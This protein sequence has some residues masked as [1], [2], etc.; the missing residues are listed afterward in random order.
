MTS[1]DEAVRSF[2]ALAETLTIDSCAVLDQAAA[3]AAALL[4]AGMNDGRDAREMVVLLGPGLL[5][6]QT[7]RELFGHQGGEVA[8]ALLTLRALVSSNATLEEAAADVATIVAR[9]SR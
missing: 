3:I 7:A 1:T 9:L 6:M 8:V 2:N 5:R 4:R